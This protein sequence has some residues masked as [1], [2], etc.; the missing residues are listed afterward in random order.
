MGAGVSVLSADWVVLVLVHRQLGCMVWSINI[1][2]FC[3][4]MEVVYSVLWEVPIHPCYSIKYLNQFEL[5]LVDCC[6]ALFM[7]SL[8]LN[9][10][11]IVRYNLERSCL[12]FFCV[13]VC[14]I[15]AFSILE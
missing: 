4:A 11:F 8:F 10:L 5:Y 7:I 13:H 15:A 14:V 2:C 3:Y 1:A 12:L 9:L 6:S